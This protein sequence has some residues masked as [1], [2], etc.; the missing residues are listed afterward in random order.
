MTSP[1]LNTLYLI[2]ACCLPKRGNDLCD[3]L[4]CSDRTLKRLIVDA[5]DLGAKIESKNI[6]GLYYWVCE[7][8]EQIEERGQLA[9]WIE[10][11]EKRTVV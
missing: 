1:L 6:G 4:D 5:N 9:K 2:R 10:L 8:W 11:E 7:N 3:L